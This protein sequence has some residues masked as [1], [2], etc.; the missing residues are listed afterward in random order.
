MISIKHSIINYS[1]R[2]LNSHYLMSAQWRA[3]ETSREWRFTVARQV[4]LASQ[5]VLVFIH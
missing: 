5:R 2:E 3:C 4:L 1:R